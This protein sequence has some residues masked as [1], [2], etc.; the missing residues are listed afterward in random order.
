MAVFVARFGCPITTPNLLHFGLKFLFWKL[1]EDV[2]TLCCQRIWTTLHNQKPKYAIEQKKRPLRVKPKMV[3]KIYSYINFPYINQS[4]NQSISQSISQS[5][6]LSIHQS[7]NQSKKVSLFFSSSSSSVFLRPLSPFPPLPPPPSHAPPPLHR[8]HGRHHDHHHH[9]G[10]HDH[11][12]FYGHHLIVTISITINITCTVMNVSH[13]S[14]SSLNAVAFLVNIMVFSCNLQ[15]YVKILVKK[16][17][18]SWLSSLA[19]GFVSCCCCMR[20]LCLRLRLSGHQGVRS[21]RPLLRCTSGTCEYHQAG[22]VQT[23]FQDVQLPGQTFIVLNTTLWTAL[24]AT[25]AASLLKRAQ[26]ISITRYFWFC[27]MWLRNP[28]CLAQPCYQV[29]NQ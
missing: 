24:S 3:K 6:N 2:R 14:P 27:S 16:Y 1:L 20:S 25:H 28:F 15:V 4:T 9:H 7:S 5:I 26:T 17:P 22:S 11:N 13:L 8:R 10:H 19:R 29:P 18:P 21:N 12:D 23:K